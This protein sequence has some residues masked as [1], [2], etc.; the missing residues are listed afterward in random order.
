MDADIIIA[1][2][3]PSGV[4]IKAPLAPIELGAFIAYLDCMVSAVAT[5]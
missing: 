3:G 2:S 1:G 4:L 5:H